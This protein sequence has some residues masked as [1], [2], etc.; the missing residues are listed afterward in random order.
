MAERKT[1][2]LCPN[3]CELYALQCIRGEI[4][5]KEEQSKEKDKKE[6]EESR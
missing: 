5:L 6:A 1:C 2:G 3:D 4:W